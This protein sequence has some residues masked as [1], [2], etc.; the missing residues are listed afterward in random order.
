VFSICKGG[1]DGGEGKIVV[2]KYSSWRL[3]RK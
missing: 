3:P 2:N 1:L